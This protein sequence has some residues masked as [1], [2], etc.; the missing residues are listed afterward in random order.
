MSESFISVSQVNNYIKNIFE[1]EIM[2]QNICVFG[3]VGSFNIS[4]GNAYFNLKDDNG[5]LPC[6]LFGASKF[7]T[8]QIGD[9]ILVR[10]SMSYYSKGGRLSFNAYSIMPYGK[11]LLYEKFLRLKAELA[12]Y[13]ELQHLIDEDNKKN[14]NFKIKE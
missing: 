8:P 13:K 6:V 4:N 9:M 5:M 3:E 2:L 7:S 11:G 10:G 14:S 12:F 1:A